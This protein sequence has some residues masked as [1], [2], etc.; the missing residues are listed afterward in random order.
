MGDRFGIWPTGTIA[1]LIGTLC[2]AFGNS[3]IT[4]LLGQFLMNL[5]M[6]LTL[7]ILAQT[8]PNYPGLAFGIA[9]SFLFPGSLV[10]LT[11]DPQLVLLILSSGSIFCFG[12]AWLL[13]LKDKTKSHE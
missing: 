10:R 6:P 12:T 3:H 2:L 9:A 4:F 8:L 1:L 13:F 5:L 11:W 7:Y